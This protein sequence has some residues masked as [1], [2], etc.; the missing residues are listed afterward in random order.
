MEAIRDVYS[1]SDSSDE[2][3]MLKNEDE[4]FRSSTPL[5]ESPP[6]TDLLSRKRSLK[7]DSNDGSKKKS[8]TKP[9]VDLPPLRLHY[10]QSEQAHPK[11]QTT[12]SAKRG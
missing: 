5:H 2:G 8:R 12:N 4:V 9:A 7:P 10:M 3:E 6:P 1:S 11:P